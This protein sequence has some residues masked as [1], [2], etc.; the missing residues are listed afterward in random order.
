MVLVDLTSLDGTSQPAPNTQKLPKQ[1]S[2]NGECWSCGNNRALQTAATVCSVQVSI[3]LLTNSHCN[4]HFA[5]FVR[6]TPSTNVAGA[7][8][9]SPKESAASSPP[10][11]AQPLVTSPPTHHEPDH[12]ELCIVDPLQEAD[13]ND[14]G[15]QASTA[16]K[17]KNRVAKDTTVKAWRGK[18]A[19]L[20]VLGCNKEQKWVGVCQWCC[21]HCPDAAKNSFGNKD[22]IVLRDGNQLKGHAGTGG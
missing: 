11:A 13:P 6:T 19:W 5:G 17:Q 9:S 12:D 21:D 18:F 7:A 1:T 22:G 3:S 10:P 15:Q 4:T 20:K 8:S 16:K 2:L 14:A